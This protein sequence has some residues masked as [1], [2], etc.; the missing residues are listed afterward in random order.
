MGLFPLGFTRETRDE[1]IWYYQ[2][3]LGVIMVAIEKLL[4]WLTTVHCPL[5]T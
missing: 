3:K 2:K 4:R 1:K 5:L